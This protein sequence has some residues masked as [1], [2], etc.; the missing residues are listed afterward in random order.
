MSN[1]VVFAL[2]AILALGAAGWK[3]PL[4]KKETALAKLE[5]EGKYLKCFRK[6]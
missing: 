6:N 3:A 4:I 5:H 1:C 2:L